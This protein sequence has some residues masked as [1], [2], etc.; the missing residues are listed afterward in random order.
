ME[1]SS[2]IIW[3]SLCMDASLIPSVRHS[4]DVET[5]ILTGRFIQLARGL[6]HLLILCSAGT[7]SGERPLDFGHDVRPL[8][9]DH[10]YQCHGPDDKARSSELRLDKRESAFAD[11]GGYAA[12]VAG[13]ADASEAIRRILSDD[14]DERMPPA[15]AKFDLTDQQRDARSMGER[16]S[17]VARPLGFSKADCGPTADGCRQ[18]LGPQSDR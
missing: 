4:F 11:L 9:S 13:D 12:I 1:R 14:P 5:T 15:E 2:F 10:C 8:L 18:D 6:S 17:C 3:F 7:A 16:R